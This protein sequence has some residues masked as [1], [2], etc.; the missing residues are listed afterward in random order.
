MKNTLL[1]LL[2]LPADIYEN[3]VFEN[4]LLWCDLKSN[5]RTD[6]QKL[7]ANP[8]L[9]RWWMIQYAE[10]EQQFIEEAAEYHGHCDKYVMRK[11]YTET[12]I[13]ISQYYCTPLIILARNLKPITPQFN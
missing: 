2:D 6:C 1:H 3:H 9:F 7:L 10:L 8:A 4:Y 12:V 13:K 5:S 11:F